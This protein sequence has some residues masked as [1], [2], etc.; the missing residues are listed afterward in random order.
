MWFELEPVQL[1]TR[2]GARQATVGWWPSPAAPGRGGGGSSSRSPL[3]LTHPHSTNAMSLLWQRRALASLTPVAQAQARLACRF[4]PPTASAVTTVRR[5][6]PAAAG[7]HAWMRGIHTGSM[8]WSEVPPTVTPAAAATPATPVTPSS[9][10]GSSTP[11]PRA[12]KPK[13]DRSRTGGS[14]TRRD[15][16]NDNMLQYLLGLAV[17]V[18][19]ASWAAVPL[20]RAFCAHT[21]YGGTTQT[22]KD[23]T[24]LA[25]L[26]PSKREVTISFNADVSP[27]MHWKFVPSQ[28]QLKVKLGEPCLAFYKATNLRDKAITGVA[29]YNV[30]PMKTGAYFHKIQCFCISIGSIVSFADGL[31][32]KIESCES[33]RD[34]LTF[35]PDDAA[36][37]SPVSSSLPGG[38]L[39]GRSEGLLIQGEKEC[40]EVV[41]EDGRTLECTP[42]H[43]LFTTQGWMEAQHLVLDSNSCRVLCGPDVVLDEPMVGD[44][45]FTLDLPHAKRTLTLEHERDACFAF[46]RLLG[47]TLSSNEKQSATLHLDHELDVDAVM[48]DL[49]TLGVQTLPVVEK[50]DDNVHKVVLHEALSRDLM[51]HA[52][53][54]LPAFVT[55]AATPQCVK[56]EFLAAYFGGVDVDNTCSEEEETMQLSLSVTESIESLLVNEF[57][58]EKVDTKEMRMHLSPVDTKR[59]AETIG[60]RY[61]SHKQM[62][63][64]VAASWFRMQATLNDKSSAINLLDWLESINARQL[65]SSK[66]AV[67]QER[68]SW[69]VIG[70]KVVQR[71]ALAGVKPTFDLS[72]SGTHS[73][74]A[75]GMVVHNCFDEQR[76]RANETVDMPVFF[77]IDPA[78]EE[79]ANCNDATHLTL[80]YTFFPVED[81]E[82]D[83]RTE[84]EKDKEMMGIRSHGTGIMPDFGHGTVPKQQGPSGSNPPK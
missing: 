47:R 53:A 6:V 48:R 45:T 2:F 64:T 67:P 52:G 8:R 3:L 36:A 49:T 62:R 42:D 16:S 59:F 25:T 5:A 26:T 77:Y 66:V 24:K 39:A 11:Q 78:M 81:D 60:F 33:L 13:S 23:G 7:Q 58:F 75:S 82:D 29:T 35:D 12:S 65:F 55:D 4:V 30:T 41:L 57:G 73:F 38:V 69:P 61:A 74:L 68:S 63:L 37:S 32:R 71:T 79:D 18:V 10:S 56:R 50:S 21:G 20:Y 44:E 70:L 54:A 51:H 19:G 80:S 14:N 43:R 17:L 9:T 40:V 31:G 15:K 22:D 84:E 27:S 83:V 46:A 76:L 1:L 28:P 72:V 34:V